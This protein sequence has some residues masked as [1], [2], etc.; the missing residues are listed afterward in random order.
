MPA[1]GFRRIIDI[2]AAYCRAMRDAVYGHGGSVNADVAPHDPI[3]HIAS[4][5]RP[6]ECRFPPLKA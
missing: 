4:Q 1:K 6:I 5:T 3:A 2:V